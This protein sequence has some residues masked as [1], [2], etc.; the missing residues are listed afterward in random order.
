MQD[1]T[2]EM[3]YP[4]LFMELLSLLLVPL[5][6][7]TVPLF[8]PQGK[9][10]EIEFSRGGE[11]LGGRVSNFLLEKSRVHSISKGERTFHIFYQVLIG[12]VH[13]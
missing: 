11:P 13:N 10:I 12:G 7:L 6:S 2:T 8:S 5:H 1:T 4:S 9:Y 3:V